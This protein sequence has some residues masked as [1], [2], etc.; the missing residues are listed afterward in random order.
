MN[1]AIQEGKIQVIAIIVAVIFSLLLHR[2]IV[3]IHPL[4]GH[5]RSLSGITILGV[6]WALTVVLC[7]FLYQ[8]HGWVKWVLG[9]LLATSALP[10][11]LLVLMSISYSVHRFNWLLIPFIIQ[12]IASW[13]LLRS[14]QIKAF[15]SSQRAEQSR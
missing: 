6:Q 8:G 15:L 13:V 11:L 5:S 7:Y 12:L 2:V 4:D 3:A 1:S 10:G 14:P 9:V